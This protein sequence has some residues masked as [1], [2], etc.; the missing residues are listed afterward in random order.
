MRGYINLILVN[1][2]TNIRAIKDEVIR[3]QVLTSGIEG[4]I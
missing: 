3:G 2:I 4:Q 1:L